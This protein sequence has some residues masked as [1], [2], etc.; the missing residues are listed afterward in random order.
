MTTSTETLT[1]HDAAARL[2]DDDGTVLVSIRGG[3][4]PTWLAWH[5]DGAWH[6]AST[7]DQVHGEVVAWALTPEG[8]FPGA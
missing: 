8:W 4:E 2:P 3:T 1:W 7:G 6:D 5:A